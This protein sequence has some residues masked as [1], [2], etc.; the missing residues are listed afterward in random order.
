MEKYLIITDSGYTE[1]TGNSNLIKLINEFIISDN[2][3]FKIEKLT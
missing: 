3:I 1:V 2:K